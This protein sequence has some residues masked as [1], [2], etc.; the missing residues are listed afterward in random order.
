MRMVTWLLSFMFTSQFLIMHLQQKVNHSWLW[1]YGI[2]A[3]YGGKVLYGII[4][5]MVVV[6]NVF[7]KL[8]QMSGFYVLSTSFLN[9]HFSIFQSFYRI[10]HSFLIQDQNSNR[11]CVRKKVPFQLKSRLFGPKKSAF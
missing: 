2:V 9:N 1:N 7:F 3:V 6:L 5:L 11:R 4:F 8:L 10:M